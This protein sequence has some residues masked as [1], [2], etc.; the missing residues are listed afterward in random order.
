MLELDDQG[1]SLCQGA[2]RVGGVVILFAPAGPIAQEKAFVVIVDKATPVKWLSLAELRRIF[3]KRTRMSPHGES[4]VP[5]D[6][7]AASPSD[8][9]D[10]AASERVHH[11]RQRR[12]LVLFLLLDNGPTHDAVQP[13]RKRTKGCVAVRCASD[14]L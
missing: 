11:A 3:M 9:E 12:S 1:D 10:V 8:F 5:V 2:A 4:I 6:W 14:A 13:F 7:D